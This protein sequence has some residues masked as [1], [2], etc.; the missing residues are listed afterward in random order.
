MAVLGNPSGGGDA[1]AVPTGPAVSMEAE[2]LS[3]LVR[4][5]GITAGCGVPADG[6][7]GW[8]V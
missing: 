6:E 1:R 3:F 5:D 8:L 7:N 2:V 4:K